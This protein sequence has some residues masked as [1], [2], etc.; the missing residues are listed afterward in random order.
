MAMTGRAGMKLRPGRVLKP[1]ANP[2]G[3][4]YVN[5]SRPGFRQTFQ[6]HVL[7]M[8]TFVGPCPEGKQVR[9]L[10]GDPGNNRWAPGDNE[11]EIRAAGGNLIYGTPKKNAEDRD[12]RHGRNFQSNKTHC[13][14]DHEYTPENTYVVPATGVRQCK[15]CRD[16]GRPAPSCSKCDKPAKSHGL[17]GTHDMARRRALLSGEK[18]EEIRRKDA[19][20]ARQ[21]R[22]QKA[23]GDASDAA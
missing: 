22:A 16:G 1:H 10:D 3:Y 4:R 14:Y 21:K 8:L 9:H 13:P 20:R 12:E 18:L 7:V 17:C 2:H 15:T 6:V 23:I 11:A 19:E 5:F